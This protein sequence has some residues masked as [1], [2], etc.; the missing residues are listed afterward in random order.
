MK[1]NQE[2]LSVEFLEKADIRLDQLMVWDEQTHEP[3]LTQI[4]DIVLQFILPSA[5]P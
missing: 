4:E 5:T 2:K 3:N 1:T